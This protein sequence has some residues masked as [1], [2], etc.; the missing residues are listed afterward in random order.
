M[1]SAFGWLFK[2]FVHTGAQFLDNVF[3][4]NEARVYLDRYI[5]AQNFLLRA[6]KKLYEFKTEGLH[7]EKFDLWCGISRQRIES[8]L[9]FDVTINEEKCLEVISDFIANSESNER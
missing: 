5:N 1:H 6:S 7:L 8:A 9:F 3:L 2:T 4:S